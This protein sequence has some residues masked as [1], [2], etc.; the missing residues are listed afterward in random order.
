MAW[1]KEQERG[2]AWATVRA[3]LDRVEAQRLR[4]LGVQAEEGLEDLE[5][6]GAG[7]LAMAAGLALG[8]ALEAVRIDGQEWPSK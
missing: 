5:R 1:A 4:G 2:V 3:A 8:V 7:V 6:L